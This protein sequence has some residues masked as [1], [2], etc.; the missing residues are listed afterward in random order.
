[1]PQPAPQLLG[2]VMLDILCGT[3]DSGLEAVRTRTTM[4]LDDNSLQP[5]KTRAVV[6]GRIEIRPQT[7]QKRQY[8]STDDARAK[9]TLEKRLDSGEQHPSQALAGFEQYVAYKAIAHHHV[10]FTAIEPIALDEAL[11]IEINGLLQQQRSLLDLLIALDLFGTDIQQRDPRLLSSQRFGRHSPHDSKLEKLLGRAVDIRTQIQQQ[12]WLSLRRECC[13]HCRS[14]DT[15]QRSQNL[16]RQC[17]ERTGITGAYTGIGITVANLLEGYAH[18]RAWFATQSLSRPFSHTD[19]FRR[20]DDFQART[21]D[22]RMLGDKLFEKGGLADED[23]MQRGAFSQ[24]RQT[25]RNNAVGTEVP[26]HCIDRDDR[27]GQGLL[28]STL[29]DHL[30]TTVE[31][32][33][34]YVVTQVDFTSA[35]FHGQSV[36]LESV[37]GTTHITG[38]TG[39]FVL[40][41]S[42]LD[43]LL[44]VWVTL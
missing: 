26:T 30:A 31:T 21:I 42:H 24:T 38:G 35:L 27:S 28:V 32:V 29:V 44:N 36:R 40:L 1:M 33:R 13:H 34:G 7:A 41:N 22:P 15:W 43:Q 37:M 39:F 12:T 9:R 20:I 6:L 16:A 4:T 5:E 25:G 10:G 17:H 2:K 18:G 23:Q 11:I 3:Q 8:E 19:D 14:I